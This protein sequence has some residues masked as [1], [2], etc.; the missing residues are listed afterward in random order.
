MH[1]TPT[2]SPAQPPIHYRIDPTLHLLDIELLEI[3]SASALVAEF[4]QMQQN[5]AIAA[6]QSI[7][8]ECSYL[9]GVPTPHKVRELAMAFVAQ[10]HGEVRGRWAIVATWSWIYDAARLFVTL[11]SAPASNVRVFKSREAALEWLAPTARPR[12]LDRTQ[13]WAREARV[14]QEIA[15]R[16]K[17]WQ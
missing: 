3:E 2:W 13:S 12:S 16:G 15:R 6:A 11:A 7:C 4:L 10:T 14:L 1:L 5:P 8:V 9:S 17:L